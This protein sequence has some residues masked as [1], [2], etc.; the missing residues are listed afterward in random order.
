MNNDP[1]KLEYHHLSYIGHGVKIKLDVEI[2][3]YAIIGSEAENKHT[4]VNEKAEYTT[5]GRGT[6]IR[7][8]VTINAPIEDETVVGKFCYIMAKSHL[9]HDAKLGDHVTLSTNAIVGG[10]S[11]IGSHSVLGLNSVVHQRRY[12]GDFAMVGM[13]TP[14]TKHL[15]PFLVAYGNP[16]KWYRVNRLG[17]ERAGISNTRIEM[18]EDYY[19]W[20]W[21]NKNNEDHPIYHDRFTAPIMNKFKAF[22]GDEKITEFGGNVQESAMIGKDDDIEYIL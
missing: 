18:I 12:V 15:S 5:I 14:L 9:G 13:L 22:V 10:H 21:Y 17:L 3:P 20:H 6:V 2:F 11:V 1:H 16:A 8:F 7:E 4:K 19:R